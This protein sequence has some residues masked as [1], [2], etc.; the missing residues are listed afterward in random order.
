MLHAALVFL[1]VAVVG[2]IVLYSGIA[3]D[4]I[5]LKLVFPVAFALYVFTL[6]RGLRRSDRR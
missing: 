5:P 4:S 2:S 3:E 6:L 1:I